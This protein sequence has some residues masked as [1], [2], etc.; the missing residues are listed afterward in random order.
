MTRIRYGSINN[1]YWMQEGTLLLKLYVDPKKAHSHDKISIRMLKICSSSICKTLECIFC[2]LLVI[3]KFPSHWKRANVVPVKQIVK[4][5]CPV[6]NLR[7]WN[8]Q[9]ENFVENVLVLS[10]QFGFN[11]ED[12]YISQFLTIIHEIYKSFEWGC[13][14]R[15]VFLD[16]FKAF[17]KV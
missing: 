1:R 7:I 17:D 13:E 8:F 16:I 6:E 14:V 15:G 9:F 10:N 2:Q 5:Y 11:F 12:S 3:G 4:L